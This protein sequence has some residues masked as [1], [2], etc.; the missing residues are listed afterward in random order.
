MLTTSSQWNLTQQ[1][2]SYNQVFY[3]SLPVCRYLLLLLF[4][5][6][7]GSSRTSRQRYSHITVLQT[8]RGH[9]DLSHDDLGRS[10]CLAYTAEKVELIPIRYL[11]SIHYNISGCAQHGQ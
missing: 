9:C 6:W 5:R 3:T 7:C 11:A 2:N 4:I 1:I 8:S 10:R